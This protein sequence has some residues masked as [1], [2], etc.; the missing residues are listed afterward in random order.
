[1]RKKGLAVL[2]LA[3]VLASVPVFSFGSGSTQG[4]GSLDQPTI[5]GGSSSS[6]SSGG[7]SSGGSSSSSSSSTWEILP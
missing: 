4:G 5:S 1:M 6:S 3:V 2:A 7:S